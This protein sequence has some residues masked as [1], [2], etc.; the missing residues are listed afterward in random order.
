MDD[1]ETLTKYKDIFEAIF[2]EVEYEHSSKT[3]KFINMK[4]DEKK[5]NQPKEEKAPESNQWQN[6]WAVLI[7]VRFVYRL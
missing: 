3:V 7:L 6:L 2:S 4:G 1:T 5:G